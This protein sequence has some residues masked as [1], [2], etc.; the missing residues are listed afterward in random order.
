MKRQLFACPPVVDATD[1]REVK[2]YRISTKLDSEP[3]LTSLVDAEE[4]DVSC[5]MPAQLKA[6]A[7]G[8]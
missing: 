8:D 4:M 6:L 5:W 3:D 1:S 7:S 2:G